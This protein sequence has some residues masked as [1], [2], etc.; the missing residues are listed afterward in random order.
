MPLSAWT[1]PD[2]HIRRDLAFLPA[3]KF[4]FRNLPFLLYSS[5]HHILSS[6]IGSRDFKKWHGNT[7]HMRQVTIL[8]GRWSIA[9]GI[10]YMPLCF[11]TLT[12]SFSIPPI[13]RATSQRLLQSSNARSNMMKKIS[14]I[15]QTCSE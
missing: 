4:L 1:L 7:K 9:D 15:S 3:K 11:G 10:E 5:N 6:T 2:P 12:L 8:F 14:S 13:T